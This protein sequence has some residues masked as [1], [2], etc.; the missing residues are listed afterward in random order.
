[1]T[2]EQ[3]KILVEQY[4]PLVFS[5]CYQLVRDYQEAQNLA[6]DTF[7]SAF[8]HIDT[9]KESNL[10]AWLTRIAANKA[11]DFLKSAYNRRVALSEDMSE[12]EVLREENSPERLYISN[13]STQHVQQTILDLKEP[14]HKVSVLFFLEE[15]SIEEISLALGRPKKTVQTQLYRAKQLLQKLLKEE[16]TQI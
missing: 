5:I 4:Q 11:K 12:L 13:E 1:M 6:Q 9:V 7:V 8:A 10:R 15:K 2:T 3:F 14:Y 16:D